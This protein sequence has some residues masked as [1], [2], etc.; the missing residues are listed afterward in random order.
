V[1]HF[2]SILFMLIGLE[3]FA[4]TNTVDH[5]SAA[6]TRA[7]VKMQ[8]AKNIYLT[9]EMDERSFLSNFTQFQF[10]QRSML[11]WQFNKRYDV[12]V[13]YAFLLNKS[14]SPENKTTFAVPEIRPHQDFYIKQFPSEK[15]Q[16]QHRFRF[17]ERFIRNS[18][19]TELLQGHFFVFRPRYQ[20]TI[21]YEFWKN[22]K[23]RNVTIFFFEETFLQFGKTIQRYFEQ[24]RFAAG[25]RFGFN[26]GFSCSA[27][28]MNQFQQ[29]QKGTEF[30]DRH[31][32]L[33]TLSK[34]IAFKSE[35]H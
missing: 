17:D 16:L 15:L 35:N 3:S 6:W 31:N 28:Y 32:L 27:A 30:T 2:A 13:C 10:V 4:Q 20:F 12:A 24:Q 25:V 14:S 5:Q 23:N 8:F 7:S 33:I 34:T 29:P 18:S 9:V 19:K 26:H 1:K 11:G 22:D 21:S